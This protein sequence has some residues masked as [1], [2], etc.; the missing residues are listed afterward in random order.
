MPTPP[1]PQ[2]S[3]VR[4]ET[5]LAHRQW[6]HALA[7]SL[8]RDESSAD[9]VAQ[10]TWQV[11]LQ[12]PPRNAG[13]AR[14]WLG[15][16]VR[17]IVLESQR[18]HVRRERREAVAAR[19]E[20]VSATGDIVARVEIDRAVVNSV[21]ELPEPYRTT[22]LLRF[23]DG[24]PPRDIAAR[25]DVPV[26][27]VRSRVRRGLER[28]R[29]GLDGRHGGERGVWE[30]AIVP[31]LAGP[32]GLAAPD[33][34][35]SSASTAGAPVT[36]TVA[37]F[38]ATVAA[39]AI[40]VLA[41]LQ[42]ESVRRPAAGGGGAAFPETD[43]LVAAKQA[44]DTD[45]AELV[46]IRGRIE[47]LRAAIVARET[48]LAQLTQSLASVPASAPVAAP[49][50]VP[51]TAAF[52]PPFQFPEYY[53]ALATVD[54]DDLGKHIA[55]IIPLLAEIH[56]DRRGGRSLKPETVG[57]MQAHNGALVAIVGPLEES[58]PGGAANSALTHPAF[59]ATMAAALC[60]TLDVPL[61]AAQITALDRAAKDASEAVAR[62]V[63]GSEERE[64]YLESL[65]EETGAKLEFVT[66]LYALLTPEQRA[67]LARD[68]VRGRIGYDLF[69]PSQIWVGVVETGTFSAG[70]DVG[71]VIASGLTRELRLDPNGRDALQK[72]VNEW[73]AD[74]P[75]DYLGQAPIPFED[76][77][78]AHPIEDVIV[79]ARHMVELMRRIVRLDLSAVQRQSI[80][81]SK[82]VLILR[83]TRQ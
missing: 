65:I 3:P 69:S 46:G 29:A 56:G 72:V 53:A 45:R 19:P 33:A 40:G 74:L 22:L 71:A 8:V 80:R 15:S 36:T 42:L 63:K 70:T 2:P 48:Q 41:G 16:V 30:A 39:L 35:G 78:D 7:R 18:R 59:A 82:Q 4:I 61:T 47:T 83:R 21:A 6:V 24:L 32:G 57:Q 26:E 76:L 81:N 67:L 51:P 58:F 77:E 13:A 28:V 54:W 64:F 43:A 62:A 50:D 12:S 55:K 34:G 52:A 37:T 17:R 44:R 11:A 79:A 23:Y 5:L 14:A 66:A 10:Q 49:V 1:T 38:V 73:F 9:D 25:M 31:F 20:G 27:T 68:E 60:H 75:E